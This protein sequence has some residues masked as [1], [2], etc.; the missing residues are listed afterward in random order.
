KYGDG[1]ALS[2]LYWT[3]IGEPEKPAQAEVVKRDGTKM[4]VRIPPAKPTSGPVTS[5]QVVVVV[6]DD[7]ARVIIFQILYIDFFDKKSIVIGKS[8]FLKNNRFYLKNID[9]NKIDIFGIF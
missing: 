5:Y 4:Y 6:D 7:G 9:F 8:I 2:G 3:Q 1:P